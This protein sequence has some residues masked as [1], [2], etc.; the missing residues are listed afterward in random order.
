MLLALNNIKKV[1]EVVNR[2]KA[3]GDIRGVTYI[4]G[5]F[6]RFGLIDMSDEVKEKMGHP[7]DRKK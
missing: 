5:M 4:Y 3:L 1:G 6:Y 7:K 2:P